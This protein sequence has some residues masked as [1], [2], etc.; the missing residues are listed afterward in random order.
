MVVT[1]TPPLETFEFGIPHLL[2]PITITLLDN[3]GV[4]TALGGT[5]IEFICCDELSLVMLLCKP[6]TDPP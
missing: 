4:G 6:P 2:E 3:G 1:V 5:G